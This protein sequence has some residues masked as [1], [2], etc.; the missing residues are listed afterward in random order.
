M[1][2]EIE[3]LAKILLKPRVSHEY[4]GNKRIDDSFKDRIE[5][6]NGTVRWLTARLKCNMRTTLEHQ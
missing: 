1:K 6:L 2:V 3:I 4:S 5:V